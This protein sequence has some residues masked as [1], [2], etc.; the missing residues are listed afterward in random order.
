LIQTKG[1]CQGLGL[2]VM[3]NKRIYM[4]LYYNGIIWTCLIVSIC[5][6]DP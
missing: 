5:L 2:Y 4:V 1:Q 3:T 6:H